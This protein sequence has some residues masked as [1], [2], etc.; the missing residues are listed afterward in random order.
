MNQSL[1]YTLYLLVPIVLAG[2]YFLRGYITGDGNAMAP[3][4]TTQTQPQR[5]NRLL[6]RALII[7][8]EPFSNRI[9]TTGTV[10][11][12]E[13]VN[14]R[15]ETSGRIIQMNIREGLPVR[16]GDVLV[17]IND[18]ELQAELMRTRL[19]L[20]L[21]EIRETRQL[22]LLENRAIARE[23]YEVALN[24]VNTLKAEIDL[25]QAR[26]DKTEIRAPFNGSIGLRNVSTG[27]YITPSDVVATLQDYSTIRIDFSIPERHAALVNNG[28]R[29]Y[30]T[31]QG[32][33][34]R[35]EGQIMAIEPRIDATTR[36]LQ[37]RATAPNRDTGIFPG[38]FVEIELQLAEIPDAILVPSEAVIPELGGHSM[39]VTR[40]GLADRVQV[41]TGVRTET[42]VQIT[43]G[44]V[45]GDTILTT[46]ILQLRENLPVRL[47][48]ID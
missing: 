1:K 9:N 23:D 32:S 15:S 47:S 29:I 20:E 30:F 6:V 35:Y 18:A 46:G 12:S 37:L 25:I 27:A 26:I 16:R 11:A 28:D 2:G 33:Q 21:A 31:R 41:N 5:D 22:A 40:N 44:L 3:A 8:A 39:F 24:Q 19:Q 42:R 38:A 14:L 13:E 17:K 45:P 36:T 34:N 48:F 10:L 7:E 4:E 43:D